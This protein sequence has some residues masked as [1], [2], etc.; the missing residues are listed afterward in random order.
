MI[1][2]CT[3]L[4]FLRTKFR[5]NKQP[6]LQRREE[7]IC[8]VGGGI[9]GCVASRYLANKGYNITLIEQDNE[10]CNRTTGANGSLILPS[11]ISK[12]GDRLDIKSTLVTIFYHPRWTFNYLLGYFDQARNIARQSELAF[13]SVSIFRH[14]LPE[15]CKFFENVKYPDGTIRPNVYQIYMPYLARKLVDH[16][17]ISVKLNT[18]ITKIN[19]DENRVTSIENDTGDKISADAFVLCRGTTDG[20]VLTLPIWGQTLARKTK[21]PLFSEITIKHSVNNIFDENTAEFN[22]RLTFGAIVRK[23]LDDAKKDLVINESSEEWEDVRTEARPFTPDYLPV[24]C[25]DSK[26]N[27]LYYNGGH[28]FLGTLAFAS[29]KILHNVMKGKENRWTYWTR[30]R[31]F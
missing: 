2:N 31:F 22:E 10:L 29:A 13:V 19:T 28:G 14:M 20:P 18:K 17:N 6:Q 5:C 30:D 4:L 9:V 8:I 21:K 1:T 12:V 16:P 25:R 15:E 27:N 11:S 3:A 26:F 23:N 7:N 24:V